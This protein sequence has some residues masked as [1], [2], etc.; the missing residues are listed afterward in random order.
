MGIVFVHDHKFREIDGEI[1]SPGGLPNE[2]FERY[3]S[4]F[5]KVV[6]IGRILHETEA[7]NRY[8]KITNPDVTVLDGG[9]LQSEVARCGAVIARLPS[10]LGVSAI[11]LAKEYRKPYLVEAVGCP[12]DSLWNYG[13]KGKLAAPYFYWQMKRNVRSAGYVVYVTSGF[14]QKR[15]PTKGKSVS[16]SNVDI[17]AAEDTVLNKRLERIREKTRGK[18]RLIIGT[19][20][21][22]DVPYKGQRFV[23][24]AFKILRDQGIDGFEYQVVGAGDAAYLRDY[25]EELGVADR[26]AVL[27]AMPHDKVMEWLD[28][29]DLYIQPSLQEGLPR[30][31]IE[32]MSRGLPAL[33]ARTGGI[34]ELLQNE[35]VFGTKNKK[36]IPKELSKRIVSICRPEIMEKEAVRNFGL[37]NTEYSRDV[38]NQRRRDF[39]MLFKAENRIQ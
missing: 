4:A 10:A 24:D 20:A 8:S 34:P 19:T 29:I 15:Y 22:V 16:C 21:A 11:K 5:G 2:V 30:A 12:W 32:A 14:L 17:C 3:T 37:A 18:G 9:S 28:T 13:I 35:F 25:A 23:L 36:K 1:Y 31:L 26:L 6:V 7:K 38:I 27:G 33:G 39:F